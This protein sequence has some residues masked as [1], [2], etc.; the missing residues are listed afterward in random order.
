VA[1]EYYY[2]YYYTW[3]LLWW[4]CRTT[5]AGPPYNVSVTFCT[6]KKSHNI[7]IP[8]YSWL[9]TF[10][11]VVFSSMWVLLIF[12]SDSSWK[13]FMNFTCCIYS[14]SEILLWY[15]S[16]CLT[17]WSSAKSVPP[18]ASVLLCWY[19]LITVALQ[20]VAI[21]LTLFCIVVSSKASG[22]P[23]TRHSYVPLLQ[24]SRTLCS[25]KF[26]VVTI[27]SCSLACQIDRK[28]FVILENAI[29]VR[30]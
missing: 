23:V 8:A 3:V 4:R 9:Y 19:S 1:S 13:P 10:W 16:T 2:Y 22:L 12:V 7:W 30:L 20:P 14:L 5:A 15:L 18:V 27:I 21:T 17:Y 28:Y 11:W 24:T 6:L 26:F 25:I 29:T